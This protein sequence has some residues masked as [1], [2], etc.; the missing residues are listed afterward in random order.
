[1]LK[2]KDQDITG[3]IQ[4]IDSLKE[5]LAPLSLERAKLYNKANKLITP[6]VE[7]FLSA[8]EE[9][10]TKDLVCSEIE[11]LIRIAHEV[12]KEHSEK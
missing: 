11:S 12:L 3:L 9:Y 6:E 2:E 7:L 10:H 8:K 1:M 4:Y 5:K